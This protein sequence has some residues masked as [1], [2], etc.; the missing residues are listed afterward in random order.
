LWDFVVKLR[1]R[2]DDSQDDTISI[3]TKSRWAIQG[4]IPGMVKGLFASA[5]H[6]G[7]FVVNPGGTGGRS[8]VT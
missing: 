1:V 7:W 8:H 2:L 4:S 3:T 5:K 6:A